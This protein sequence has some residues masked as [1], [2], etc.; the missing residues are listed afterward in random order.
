MQRMTRGRCPCH[1]DHKTNN[2]QQKM[3]KEEA[4]Q[5]ETRVFQEINTNS[6]FTYKNTT[7]N[8]KIVFCGKMEYRSLFCF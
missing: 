2:C 3:L 6:F 5:E 1:Y 8:M 7:R 4:K